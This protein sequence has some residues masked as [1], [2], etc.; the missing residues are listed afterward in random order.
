[1]RPGSRHFI[2]TVEDCLAI[3][4]HFYNA[5]NFNKTAC[6]IMLQHFMGT[7]IVNTEHS[8]AVS[9]LIKLVNH[10][11]WITKFEGYIPADIAE[12]K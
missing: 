10:Y 4:G 7:T 12:C 6:A 9:H 11:N 3:G 8:E 2:I 1:M 5:N